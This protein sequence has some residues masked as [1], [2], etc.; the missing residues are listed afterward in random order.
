MKELYKLEVED[1]D[2]LS[3][4]AEK[5]QSRGISELWYMRLSHLHHGAL[6]ILQQIST[7]F[8]KG[9]LEKRDTCKGCTLGK[10]T[11]SSFHDKESQAQAIL[12]RVHSNVCGLFSTSSTTKHIYYV[13]FVDDFSRKCWILF[14]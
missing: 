13:I 3:T 4:K 2:A 10:Y 5:V 8:P 9:T 11:K 6:K 12:D 7:G 1:Y 14:M